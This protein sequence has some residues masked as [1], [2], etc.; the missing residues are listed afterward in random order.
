M[1]DLEAAI[2]FN[3]REVD[4]NIEGTYETI[5]ASIMKGLREV[6][7]SVG[8]CGATDCCAG[9]VKETHIDRLIRD[10][11][12]VERV[13]GKNSFYAGSSD[14]VHYKVSGWSLTK[15]KRLKV[16]KHVGE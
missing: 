8:Y 1:F 12:K 7:L 11:F 3:E 16:E 15:H 10:K 14:K 6:V 2:E 9:N 5:R 4:N 13:Q